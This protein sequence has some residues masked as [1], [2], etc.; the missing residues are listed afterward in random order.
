MAS[1]ASFTFDDT[2]LRRRLE[3]LPDRLDAYVHATVDYGSQK[4]VAYAK[5]NAKWRDRTG[6]ARSGLRT[7]TEWE[8]RKRHA[9]VLFHS[10][11]YGIW[12]EVRFAGRYAIILPTIQVM[13][14]E[15]MRLLNKLF[16]RLGSGGIR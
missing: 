14:P 13:G 6:A 11:T 3:D 2:I 8:P 10:V 12:L 16:S 1:S 5:Q 4:V 7:V 9:I 15:V